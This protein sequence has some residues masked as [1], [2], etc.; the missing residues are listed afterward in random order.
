M[1]IL[2]NSQSFSKDGIYSQIEKLSRNPGIEKIFLYS[3]IMHSL[4]EDIKNDYSKINKTEF[5]STPTLFN[6]SGFKDEK[7]TLPKEKFQDEVGI[8]SD[9]IS[10]YRWIPISRRKDTDFF[11]FSALYYFD[12]YNY[13]DRFFL[14]N[15]I[16]TVFQ[17]NEVHSSLDS[18]L[19]K[20]AKKYKIENIITSRVVGWEA[21]SAIEYH[22]FYD[23]VNEKYIRINESD[24]TQYISKGDFE[25]RKTHAKVYKDTLRKRILLNFSKTKKL[26]NGVE[27]FSIIFNKL[28]KAIFLRF[29]TIIY[30]IK[31]IQYIKKLK[32]YYVK[33]SILDVDDGKKYIYY[34]LHFDPEAA[35]LPKDGCYAN[36]LLNIRIL[37]SSIPSDWNLYVKEHPHQLDHKIY[38]GFL[39][40]QLNSMDCFRSK[41]FYDYILNMENVK[42]ISF[43]SDHQALI[44][45][46]EFVSSNTGTI[47]REASA[48]K[49]KCI[50]FS[51]DTIFNLLENVVN[52]SDY[53]DCKNIFQG[54]SI[55]KKNTTKDVNTL[56]EEYSISV[57]DLEKRSEKILE[58]A[59]NNKYLITG[60]NV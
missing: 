60:K 10:S 24:R 2:I 1:K 32:R 6:N 20:C 38:R 55:I 9:L 27:S 51:C 22:S 15:N 30:F 12:I 4:H 49:K 50:T 35:T 40:N 53:S 13:L 48:I 3:S 34:C 7:F 19:I 37:S 46:S 18:I 52:V 44:K 23:N 39:R 11:S 31:Q 41:S 25:T 14:N 21:S 57:M 47:L 17:M 59:I 16:D 43:K 29:I 54:A 36:Q 5:V 56:F 8:F 33:K 26:F 42:L 28:L 45:N 58:F